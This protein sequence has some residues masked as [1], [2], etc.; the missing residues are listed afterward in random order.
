LAS[1]SLFDGPL[2]WKIFVR[3]W[4]RRI[5]AGASLADL[6][7]VALASGRWHPADV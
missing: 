6:D 7:R 5:A 1:R 2:E 4:T 3:P